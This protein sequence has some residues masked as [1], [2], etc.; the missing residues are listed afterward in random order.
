MPV[1]RLP[2]AFQGVNTESAPEYLDAEEAVQVDNL[3]TG[4]K[5]RLIMR[6]EIETSVAV[7]HAGTVGPARVIFSYDDAAKLVMPAETPAK[8][9]SIDLATMVVTSTL[10]PNTVFTS[11]RSAQVETTY[12]NIGDVNFP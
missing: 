12:Y 4:Y 1:E 7:A 3:V 2:P 11:S 10:P 5:G 6:G 8:V 9:W